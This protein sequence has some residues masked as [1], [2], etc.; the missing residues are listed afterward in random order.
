MLTL[1]AR[2][3]VLM[4]ALGVTQAW[5][6]TTAPFRD[7]VDIEGQAVT[8][9]ADVGNGKWQVIMIWSTDCHI[10]AVMKPKMSA[11]HDKHKEGEAEVYGIALDGSQNLAA[12]KQYMHKH[13]VT[14]PTYIGDINLIA[15]N[16]EIYN[17]TPLSGT[18]T[19]MLYN[20]EGE[21]V[22]IDFGMLDV[23]AIERFMA[24][25]T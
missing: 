18:P 10:C 14:F 5:A 3:L 19:Y 6:N 20:P 11:F 13:E 15:V 23:D 2:T 4:L 12:V 24:R 8:T 7:L 9:E 1:T 25:N 17:G 21:L 16:F 22:A